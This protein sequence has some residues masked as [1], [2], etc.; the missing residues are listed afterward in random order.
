[1]GDPKKSRKKYSRPSHPWEG[2]RIKA[3][4]ELSK[5]YGLK[6]K[7]EIWRSKAELSRYRRHAKKLQAKLRYGDPQA[8]KESQELL[9][10]LSKLGILYGE[11]VSLDSILG[12]EVESILARRLQT[13]VYLKGMA[14]TMEQARQFIVHGHITVNGRK[15]TVP[16]YLVKKADEEN[17]DY[18]YSSPLKDELHPERVKKKQKADKF[19]RREEVKEPQPAPNQAAEVKMNG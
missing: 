9:E 4:K 16:G 1:V 10:K 18:F 19:D 7:T 17:I 3:E 5:K 13:I 14:N 15:V 6:N 11:D 12:L 2:E 8:V